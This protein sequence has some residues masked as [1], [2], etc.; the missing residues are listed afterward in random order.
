MFL[1]AAA[2]SSLTNLTAKTLI[3][4]FAKISDDVLNAA[5][6]IPEACCPQNKNDTVLAPETSP[7]PV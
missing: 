3:A 5:L 7:S 6:L 2:K 1:L 4:D